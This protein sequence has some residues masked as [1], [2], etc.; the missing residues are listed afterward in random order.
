MALVKGTKTGLTDSGSSGKKD[1]ATIA[2]KYEKAAA[3]REANTS[4][5]PY[6]EAQRL[7]GMARLTGGDVSTVHQTSSGDLAGGGGRAMPPDPNIRYDD[8]I[9]ADL[10]RPKIATPSI[11]YDDTI[12]AQYDREKVVQP[13]PTTTRTTTGG[14]YTGGGGTTGGTTTTTLKPVEGIKFT[15]KA[16]VKGHKERE[17]IKETQVLRCKFI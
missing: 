17:G 2:D 6:V 5:T 3:N 7:A 10:D 15:L 1:T 16:S 12:E 8:T 11:R 9:E 14:G 13:L 4:T